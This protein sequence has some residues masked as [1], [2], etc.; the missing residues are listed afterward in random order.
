M[1]SR[2]IWFLFFAWA[3]LAFA[4]FIKVFK[5]CLETCLA[6]QTLCLANENADQ[7]NNI[8]V[9]SGVTGCVGIFESC[10]IPCYQMATRE[11]AWDNKQCR[12]FCAADQI[13]CTATEIASIP[14]A[15]RD[16]S[17]VGGCF[18][19][20]L[21]CTNVCPSM[22]KFLRGEK[23]NHSE[24]APFLETIRAHQALMSNR[25]KNAV[26]ASNAS[27]SAVSKA[28]IAVAPFTSNKSEAA[29]IYP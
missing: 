7:A 24:V 12:E 19:I 14:F 27:K 16:K 2:C 20:Y 23:A 6:Q 25:T 10:K 22:S 26:T 28:L 29:S 11:G 1:T 15:P 8:L 18:D 13:T 3:P 9:R 4:D 17:V 21:S 5:N